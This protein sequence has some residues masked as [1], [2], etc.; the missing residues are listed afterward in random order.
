MSAPLCHRCG[1]GTSERQA[2]AKGMGGAC[3]HRDAVVWTIERVEI[4][5]IL[6]CHPSR[7]HRNITALVRLNLSSVPGPVP[8]CDGG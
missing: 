1:T 6:G 7:N 5:G 3:S 2:P 4:G 8:G